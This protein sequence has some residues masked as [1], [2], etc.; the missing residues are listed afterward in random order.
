VKFLF[1]CLIVAFVASTGLAADKSTKP[2]VLF[3]AVDDLNHWVGYTGR[4][5]QTKTPNLDRLSKMGV[6][7]SNASCAAPLCNPSRAAL[8]SG[9]RPSTTG[10]YD[11]G[12]NWKKFI[13]EGRGLSMT[14]KQAGYYVAGAGKIYH[15]NT[16]Y[17]G[18]WSDYMDKEGS[19]AGEHGP[20]G[21]AKVEGFHKP[22]VHDLKDQDLADWNITDYCIKQLEKKQEGPFFLACGLHKPHLPWVV[23]RKYYD[24]FPLDT[25][26]LPPH[27]TNDL[28]DVP[29]G[30]LR[31][32]HN[33]KEHKQ[34]L[35]EH[36][37]KSAVQSYLA[38]IAYTDM[39]IGRLL[40]AL[41]KSPYRDN[42]IIVFWGDHG[43]HL[44]EKEHWRKFALWEEAVRAPMI[45]YVPGMTKPGSISDRSVDFMSIYP[46]L[47][48]LAGIPVPKHV[49]GQSI[50]ALLA[51]A[52]A[53][54]TT[55]GVCTFG[56]QNH[57]AR[58]EQWR[59]IRYA[60]GGEELYNHKVDP[61]EW[62]NLTS[63]VEFK[64]VKEQLAKSFPTTNV[65]A[66]RHKGG[67]NDE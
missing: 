60:D 12:D 55:P 11:N 29:A 5:P 31:M 61:Y 25:I 2:N 38:C 43:W 7:F 44:G 9:L 27:Q 26:Q 48:D 41:E 58:S 51:D 50:K 66:K 6:S 59:Y 37:W 56:F 15:G 45:W 65:P 19:D 49:E 32:A 36:R 14:F 39:N 24:L 33:G 23:P 42:T 20:E 30:G 63:K 52:K 10:C 40:D 57:A 3:I 53:P 34:I 4:N 13:P 54:W 47:C 67:G 35:E 22:V 8:M 21:I 46:T 64:A 1:S 17:P 28:S 18:E 62:T 16:F